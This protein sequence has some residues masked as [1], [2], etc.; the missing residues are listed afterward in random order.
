MSSASHFWQEISSARLGGK[1]PSLL[2]RQRHDISLRRSTGSRSGHGDLRSPQRCRRRYSYK[3]R[4]CGPRSGRCSHRHRCRIRNDRRRRI[5]SSPTDRAISASPRDR[6]GY[7]FVRH[8]LLLIASLDNR[9]R[10]RIPGS[11]A[12]N[13]TAVAGFTVTAVVVL[14]L[15]ATPPQEISAINPSAR[16]VPANPP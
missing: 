14:T 15:P 4:S 12:N 8:E 16:K 13:T 6:P 7:A 9:R 5:K 11:S 1:V 2:H 3:S 10:P